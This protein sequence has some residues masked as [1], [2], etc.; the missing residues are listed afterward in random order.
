MMPSGPP[1]TGGEAFP[2]YLAMHNNQPDKKHPVSL[3][4]E[5]LGSN[6]KMEYVFSETGDTPVTKVFTCT[7]TLGQ[8]AEAPCIAIKEAPVGSYQG[9]AK[10][11]KEAKRLAAVEAL[12]KIFDV[13][14]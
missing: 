10:S 8:E 1:R 9:Q 14:C 3:L 12:N 4:N 5:K 13:K 6:A 11:K 2:H 7:L